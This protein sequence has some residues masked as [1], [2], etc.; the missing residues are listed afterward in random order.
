MNADRPRH[1]DRFDLLLALLPY[2]LVCLSLLSFVP[3]WDAAGYMT[4]L[5]GAFVGP[6]G[7]G[8]LNCADHPT[9]GYFGL[10]ALP[11]RLAGLHYGGVIVGNLCLG[12]LA[13]HRVTDLSALLCPGEEHR[14]VGCQKHHPR[15]E[16]RGQQRANPR[17]LPAPDVQQP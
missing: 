7:L 16:P 15:W 10:L 6:H 1:P 14:G 4:C 13:A 12:A 11:F 3:V 17:P 5:V 2:T 9:G 8:A